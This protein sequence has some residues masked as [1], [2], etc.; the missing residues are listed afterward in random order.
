M[1][2]QKN[3]YVKAIPTNIK[4]MKVK[5]IDNETIFNKTKNGKAILVIQVNGLV[6]KEANGS[7]NIVTFGVSRKKRH[8]T[9][10][11]NGFSKYIVKFDCDAGK[12]YFTLKSRH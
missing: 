1:Y 5:I 9:K 8:Y 2:V 10:T 6:F 12:Y 3:E 7:I 4:G 11:N